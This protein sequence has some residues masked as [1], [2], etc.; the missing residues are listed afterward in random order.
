MP[1][2][3]VRWLA[4][5]KKLWLPWKRLAPRGAMLSPWSVP[6]FISHSMKWLPICAKRYWYAIRQMLGFSQSANTKDAGNLTCQA[7]AQH[8]WRCLALRSASCLMIRWRMKRDFSA[9]GAIRWLTV[10]LL[11]ISYRLLSSVIEDLDGGI[12]NHDTIRFGADAGCT[13]L[14]SLPWNMGK[15]AAAQF[16]GAWG[17]MC[18]RISRGRH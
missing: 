14:V 9:I 12:P 7:I 6:V 16:L 2:G 18:A 11:G 3:A 13:I 15:D 17:P 4:C 5:C 1:A 8:G 10:G